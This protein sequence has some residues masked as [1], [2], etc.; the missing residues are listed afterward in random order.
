MSRFIYL[1]I[2]FIWIWERVERRLTVLALM[3]LLISIS[4]CGWL[5]IP[6]IEFPC[7]TEEK[8]ERSRLPHEGTSTCDSEGHS[9]GFL[10]SGDLRGAQR[11]QGCLCP[12]L[13]PVALLTCLQVPFCSLPCRCLIPTPAPP[14]LTHCDLNDG[15]ESFL[16][17]RNLYV[18]RKLFPLF[19]SFKAPDWIGCFPHTHINF[20]I[21]GHLQSKH[22]LAFCLRHGSSPNTK[23]QRG[24]TGQYNSLSRNHCVSLIHKYITL[25]WTLIIFNP[26]PI[27][28]MTCFKSL[29][30]TV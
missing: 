10:A 22:S 20:V 29:W 28:G 6:D 27:L 17:A 14:K 25:L 13:P 30:L 19:K 8:A 11:H 5:H 18:V 15:I 23:C 2:Y 4:F 24:V 1:W 3:S 12:P 16:K 21:L 9:H 7:T 26:D